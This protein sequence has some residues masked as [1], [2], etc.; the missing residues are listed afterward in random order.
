MEKPGSVFRGGI[1][2]MTK[3]STKRKSPARRAAKKFPAGG[4]AASRFVQEPPPPPNSR[5]FNTT[6]PCR[7]DH[8]Y[9]LPPADRLVGAQRSRY[10]SSKLFWILHAPRQT[11][12]T[13]FLMNWMREL[14]ASG[15][16]VACYVTVEICQEVPEPERAMPA[17]VSSAA[18]AAEM[19]TGIRPAAPPPQDPLQ[20]GKIIAILPFNP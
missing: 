10:I 16:V 17:I 11:G 15:T 12:K 14:N 18:A 6:G 4:A 1:R 9:M 20:S 7:L 3:P 19:Q 5:F 8:H 13:T 2:G